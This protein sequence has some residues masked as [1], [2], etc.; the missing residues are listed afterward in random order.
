MNKKYV[1]LK[2]FNFQWF[3]L[4]YNNTFGFNGLQSLTLVSPKGVNVHT[5]ILPKK[6]DLNIY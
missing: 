5:L 6:I 2:L 1:K 3:N 4:I